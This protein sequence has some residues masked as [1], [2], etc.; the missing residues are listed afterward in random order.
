M[1]QLF[2]KVNLYKFFGKIPFLQF[3]NRNVAKSEFCN[4]MLRK[5]SAVMAF[6]FNHQV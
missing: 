6:Y 2:A 4:D 3:G 1:K 5:I